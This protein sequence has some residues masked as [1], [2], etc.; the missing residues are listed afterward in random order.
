MRRAKVRN[1][2]QRS[3]TQ[4]SRGSL[5]GV[6]NRKVG[7][8]HG[9]VIHVLSLP[10]MCGCSNGEVLVK[11][12]PCFFV[13]FTTLS[14]YY[15]DLLRPSTDFPRTF[16]EVIYYPCMYADLWGAVDIDRDSNSLYI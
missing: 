3:T 16:H 14:A 12:L 2:A 8:L 6:P 1:L 4:A 10:A 7:R 9:A 13:P 15:W 5:N 11:C